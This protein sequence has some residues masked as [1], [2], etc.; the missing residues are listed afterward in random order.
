MP[1]GWLICALIKVT[2]T[3]RGAFLHYSI[4]AVVIFSAASTGDL[5]HVNNIFVIIYKLHLQP[6]V[7]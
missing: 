7:Q 5:I 4:Q 6:V 3:D 1:I 2:V